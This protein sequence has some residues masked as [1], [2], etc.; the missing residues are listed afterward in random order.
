MTSIPILDAS[1]GDEAL[2]ADF[3]AAYS[4]VGFAYLENHGIPPTLTQGLFAASAA[5]HAL[6]ADAKARVALNRNHRGFIAL[7]TS[8][9]VNTELAKVTKPNQ[10]ESF[11]MMREDAAETSEYLS[12][13]N[14]W[15]DLPGFREACEAYHDAMVALGQRM[16][17]VAALTLGA[18]A[19][20]FDE[21]FARPTTWLR[22]LHYPPAPAQR[23]EDLWGSAPHTDF[24]CLTFLAQDDVG[25][26]EVM[27]PGG[28]W[29][30]APPRPDA[31]IVNVGDMLHRWSNGALRSTPH[32]VI[33]ASGRERYSCPFFFD[34]NVGA[35]IKPL[36]T[37]VT[38]DRPAAFDPINFGAF[39]RAE[40]EAGYEA[41]QAPDKDNCA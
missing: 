8:T 10:S 23:P 35:D 38:H 25:G 31:L 37:C 12:G 32:R 24:G 30:S 13:P 33:N 15:P 19:D 1:Q 7:N 11:M 14:Q 22:L 36:A 27:S 2:A 3:F 16:M 28:E 4:E 6:D 17:R 9:D 18:P 26:L 39:L 29:L 34:P 20:T 41:H 5:F 21:A 40:L